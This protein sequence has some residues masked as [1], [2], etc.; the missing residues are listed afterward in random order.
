MIRSGKPP[1]THVH[2][3]RDLTPPSR[4]SFRSGVSIHSHTQFSKESLGFIPHYASRIPWISGC[5]DKACQEYRSKTGVELDFSR[6]YWTPPFG[7]KEVWL[8]ELKQIEQALG[9]FALISITDHDNIDAAKTMSNRLPI[10]LEWTVPH[11][12]GYFH[13][14]IHN[15][16]AAH[17]EAIV[18]ELARFTEGCS[19]CSALDLLSVLH[20][21]PETLVVFNHPLWD[22]ERLG[23]EAHRQA[24]QAFLAEHHEFIHAIEI[25]GFRPWKENLEVLSL[26]ESW[27]IPVVAGGDRHGASPNTVL[28]LSAATSMKEFV[29]EI[30]E[31]RISHVLLMPSYGEPMLTRQLGIAGDAVRRYPGHPPERQHW[32]DRVF[33]RDHNDRVLPLSQQVTKDLPVWLKFVAMVLQGLGNRSLHHVV[34][35]I[36]PMREGRLPQIEPRRAPFPAPHQSFHRSSYGTLREESGRQ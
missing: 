6:A 13:L 7:P 25:N 33:F 10:S 24:L 14:G 31:D 3:R 5:V 27:A 21:S 16:D 8:S 18:R 32:A 22:V 19:E 29:T 36:S 15:I 9:L 28:N 12:D 11:R 34:H 23:A 4:L 1:R 26:G 17:E 20:G 35:A 2:Q 30:R